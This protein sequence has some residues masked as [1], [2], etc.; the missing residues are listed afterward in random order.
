MSL[1]RQ[2]DDEPR[3]PQTL[4]LREAATRY[5]VSVATLKRQ[6]SY[7]ELRGAKETQ[8]RARAWRVRPEDLDAAGY[9]RRPAS[10]ADSDTEH[11]D[12]R[13]LVARLQEQ[14]GTLREEVSNLTDELTDVK[15]TTAILARELAD[16]RAG[17]QPP[18][19]MAE[20]PDGRCQS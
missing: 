8:G 11:D 14:V 5:E 12:L 16:E 19:V 18:E 17:R 1:V 4:T 13:R 2:D 7:G 3:E 20:P 10:R 9:Q 6:L 15:S